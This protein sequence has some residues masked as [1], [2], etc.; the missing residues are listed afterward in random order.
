MDSEAIEE[1][2][3]YAREILDANPQMDEANTKAKLVRDLLELLGWNFATDVELEYP[4][5]MATRT[6]KVDY[7]LLLEDTPVVFVEAKGSDSSLSDDHREQLCSYMRNQNIDWGLLT[8][9]RT[10]EV[11]QRHVK[12]SNVT[13]NRIGSVRIRELSRKTNLLSALSKESIETGEAERIA[14][15]ITEIERAKEEL[16]ENKEEI[17]EEVARTIAE[18][19]GD[20][21]SK[22]TENE[23]KT[24]VDNLV[25]EL[26]NEVNVEVETSSR[27]NDFWIKAKQQTGVTKQDGE[28]VLQDDKSSAEQLQEFVQFLFDEGYLTESDLPIESGRKRHLVHTE[29]VDQEGDEMKWPKQVGDELYVETNYST[30]TIKRRISA[31]SERFS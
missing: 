4:V 10:N 20:S 30:D 11:Y 18:R 8:N 26:E 19:V 15:R 23:A 12:N 27:D 22:Q 21:I 13:V 31:L 9:G 7:A 17:A 3:E 2:V 28:V 5:P 1:Y 6:H 14:E 16:R 29:P 25:D 24:L